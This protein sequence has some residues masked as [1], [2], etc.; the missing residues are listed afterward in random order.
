MS[1]AS[2]ARDFI[3]R[4][5][6]DTGRF[7][8]SDVGTALD[9]VAEDSQAAQRGLDDFSSATDDAGR[10]ARDLGSD[11]STASRDLRDLA[12]DAE[13]AGRDLRDLGQDTDRGSR[14]LE[15]FGNRADQTARDVD[16]AFDRI[17]RSSRAGLRERLG[18]DAD[19]AKRSLDDVKDEASQTARESAAS[20]SGGA[21]DITDAFQE[22]AANAFAGFGPAGA[23]AGLAAAVGLG[24][25]T[26]TLQN[27]A[28][29]AEKLKER[30]LELAA[31]IDSVGGNLDRVDLASK[32]REWGLEIQD[33]KS[34]WEVWQ[35]SSLTNLEVV[36][37]KAADLGISFQDLF[38]GM[39]GYDQAAAQR[40]WDELT[41]KIENYNDR[42]RDVTRDT[43]LSTEGRGR[44]VMALDAEKQAYVQV[45]EEL[46]R[47]SGV[48][49]EAARTQQLLT[50]AAGVALATQEAYGE[51]LADVA[52]SSS[53]MADAT[54][55]AARRAGDANAEVVLSIDDV[56]AA[57]Q[58]QLE[59]AANFEDNTRAVYERLGQAAVDWAL[60]QGD[61]AD[62]AMQLLAEAPLEKGQQIAR[63]YQLLGERSAADLV[64]G[65]TG[66]REQAASAGRGIGERTGEAIAQGIRGRENAVYQA[67]AAAI[68]A[69][70]RAADRNPV[71]IRTELDPSGAESGL[72]TLVGTG[73]RIRV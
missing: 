58:R 20:F 9:D 12:G 5:I 56:L 19:A 25:I 62:E 18:D 16:N 37:R 51:A 65:I 33:N 46:E 54:E 23:A 57:Q 44:A 66:R 13:K 22:V 64:A 52:D 17:A 32:I 30:I 14:D 2:R 28:E 29:E 11:A 7:D 38:A 8:T 39:S 3:A 70:Q 4:F 50:D 15:D 43:S 53:T 71:T 49:A 1:A 69:G 21:D 35:R 47:A 42:I 45:R 63:N 55:E 72:R 40:S 67:T 41:A 27:N 59:S 73:A 10:R 36:E 24:V 60:A 34:W 61:Q 31:E 6:S 68:A 26:S 48:T